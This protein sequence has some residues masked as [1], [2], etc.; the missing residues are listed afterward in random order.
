LEN[1]Y[2]L[3]VEYQVLLEKFLLQY[4]LGALRWGKE[5][6]LVLLHPEVGLSGIIILIISST[7]AR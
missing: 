5:E 1:V 7:T 2:P 3:L 4:L 6:M